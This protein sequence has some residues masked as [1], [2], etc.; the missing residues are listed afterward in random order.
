[1]WCLLFWCGISLLSFSGTYFTTVLKDL[2]F[3]WS[4]VIP[5]A[6][7]WLTW[8]LFTFPV[9]YFA[10]KFPYADTPALKFV[11]YHL[12]FFLVINILQV[13]VSAQ[14]LAFMLHTFNDGYYSNILSKTAVSGSFY[15]LIVYAAVLII[16]NSM[17]Y[18]RDLQ[19]EK[20]KT[21]E[22][23]KQLVNSRMNFLKQQL[24][25]H[26][27]FNTHHSIITLMKL[28]EKQKAIEMME[29]LSD[30]MRFALKENSTQEI[31][32]EKELS[33]LNLY[34]DI[35]KV[36]FEEKLKINIEVPEDVRQAYVP[37]MILQPIVENSIKYAVEKSSSESLI[38]VMCHKGRW[39]SYYM[40]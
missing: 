37:S 35:Q 18:Y 4:E 23:E 11:I 30:L 36:R 5:F 24:Q 9:I 39:F 21:M 34:L 12:F 26:F 13:L 31:T 22:L 15:N 14:Y 19:Q 25:P 27:L 6:T 10:I 32:L 40:Y 1:M 17:K 33:L 16:V 3:Y 2:P 8:F 29:K 20:S 38:T 28:G 7:V